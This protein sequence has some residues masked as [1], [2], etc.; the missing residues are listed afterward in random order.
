M[1]ENGYHFEVVV[2]QV[3]EENGTH[4]RIEDSVMANAHLKAS[5]VACRLSDRNT[6]DEK[7][8]VLAADTLVV[9]D[10]CVYGK[11]V[12][13]VEAQRFLVELG[14]KTHRVMTG[15]C[16]I[17]PA[18]GDSHQ[19]VETTQVVL[20]QMDADEI[21]RLFVEV[22]PL[23]K[24]AAYGYQDAPHIVR[25]LKGSQTNVMGLPMSRLRHELTLW[26]AKLPAV[27]HDERKVGD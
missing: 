19:F 1:R 5:D 14:G 22:D 3:E 24:A 4:D 10:K 9:M 13:L 17:H 2:S 25:E 18:S 26:L 12:D 6:S 8:C 21:K 15:V 23:D 20:K 7:L 16:L 27:K 11:P